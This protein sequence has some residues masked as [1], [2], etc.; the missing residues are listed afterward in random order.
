[1]STT[2]PNIPVHACCIRSIRGVSLI[3]VL[4]T[5][6]VLSV[7]LLG[8]ASMQSLSVKNTYSSYLMTNAD[9]MAND[10]ADRMR[11]NREAALG[12]RYNIDFGNESKI[13][14]VAGD[15]LSAWLDA[16]EATMPEG[17]ANIRVRADGSARIR[18][19]WLKN[20]N[21]TQTERTDN[22]APKDVSEHTTFS[23]RTQI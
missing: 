13:G 23:M 16:I 1:M 19:R 4:V 12:G 9:N 7:G 15:D 10:I 20:R 6:V 5:V 21:K 11:A 17:E 8:L 18:I 14:G 3:E 22:G 2:W